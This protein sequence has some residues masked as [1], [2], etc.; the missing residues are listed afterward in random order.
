MSE[1]SKIPKNEDVRFRDLFDPTKPRS[2]QEL[3]EARLDICKT[4]P[5]LSRNMT[6]CTKCGCFMKLKTTLKDATCPIG[7]W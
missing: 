1:E 6:R 7:K 3:I 5:F 4:C 2:E